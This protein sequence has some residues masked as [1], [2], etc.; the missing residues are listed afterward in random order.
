M[1][2]IVLAGL[3]F[4]VFPSLVWKLPIFRI[5]RVLIASTLPILAI[6]FLV[7][8]ERNVAYE[9]KKMCD[10]EGGLKIYQR[11]ENVRGVQGIGFSADT[12]RRT[13]LQFIESDLGFSTPQLARYSQTRLMPDGTI[14]NTRS[15]TPQ[16]EIIYFQ[17]NQSTAEKYHDV[18]WIDNFVTERAT[19]KILARYRRILNAGGVADR[20]FRLGG[21]GRITHNVDCATN[22]NATLDVDLVI[23]V[24]TSAPLSNFSETSIQGVSK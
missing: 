23:R 2:Q 7:I 8:D 21:P 24:I 6:A 22:V 1:I 4:F 19:E 9:V 13:K 20:I 10:E 15:E 5:Y 17:K 12:L 11:M 16:A 3:V 18:V 14:K